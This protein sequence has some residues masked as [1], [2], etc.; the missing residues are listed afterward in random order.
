MCNFTPFYFILINYC[1][2]IM[3]Y[4]IVMMS[5]E[6]MLGLKTFSLDDKETK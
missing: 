4:E 2:I 3:K 6:T 1:L 5:I